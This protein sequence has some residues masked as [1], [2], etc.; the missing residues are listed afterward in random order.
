MKEMVGCIELKGYGRNGGVA[1]MGCFD[2]EAPHI[3]R[4]KR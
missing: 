1:G 3:T 2:L 4:R